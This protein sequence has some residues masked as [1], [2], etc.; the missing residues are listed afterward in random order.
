MSTGSIW[1]DPDDL[2]PDWRPPSRL[3][4]VPRWVKVLTPIAVLA[5]VVAVVQGLHGFAEADDIETRVPTGSTIVSGTLSI[6]PRLAEWSW[7]GSAKAW[8]VSISA[9]CGQ[10]DVAG[11][12]PQTPSYHLDDALVVGRPNTHDVS[13]RALVN[14]GESVRGQSRTDYSALTPGAPP[15]PCSVEFDFDPGNAPPESEV[16]L[17]VFDLHY[18]SEDLS[19]QGGS[20]WLTGSRATSVRVPAVIRV[21]YSED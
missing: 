1:V 13:T 2:D 14:F 12:A 6:T 21:P 15:I 20:R 5:L 17:L 7:D 19:Q 8:K 11:D 9:S 10:V 18:R 4:L 16:T 3:S